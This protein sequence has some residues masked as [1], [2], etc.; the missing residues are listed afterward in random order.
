M[1]RSFVAG[2]E[3]AKDA[4]AQTGE[5]IKNSLED[6]GGGEALDELGEKASEAMEKLG[7]LSK[8]MLEKFAGLG[9]GLK[10]VAELMGVGFL[11]EAITKTVGEFVEL[12]TEVQ[13]T[14]TIMGTSN[15]EAHAWVDAAELSGV[16]ANTF[17]QAARAMNAQ[18]L[19]GGKQLHDMKISLTDAGGAMKT[20]GQL[21]EDGINKLDTYTASANK[22]ALAQKLGGRAWID[23]AANGQ[24][25][26]DNLEKQ[27]EEF[28]NVGSR[29]DILVA[30]TKAM[31]AATAQMSI[32]WQ[33][34]VTSAAPALT[35]ALKSVDE[36]LMALTA[37]AQAATIAIQGVFRMASG[38]ADVA[39][40]I[41]KLFASAGSENPLTDPS[42]AASRAAGMDQITAAAKR[43]GDAF[44]DTGN[45]IDKVYKDL[46]KQRGQLWV[47]HLKMIQSDLQDVGTAGEGVANAAKAPA[48]PANIPKGGGGQKGGGGGADPMAGMDDTLVSS[49]NAMDKMGAEF[50]KF[51]SEA[52]MA[53][54]ASQ[55]SFETLKERATNDYQVMTDAHKAFANAVKTGDVEAA[56]ASEKDWHDASQKF[57]QDWDAAAAKAK[58]DMQQIKARRIKWPARYRAS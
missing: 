7:E 30:Q 48:P 14:A 5:E 46:D 22:N 52:Q 17:A 29:E 39:G 56:K 23:L 27:K 6:S 28:A 55:E 54:K 18:V 20:T 50:Q 38:L 1:C 16:S 34:I 11:G 4:A 36:A 51:G 8:E 15:A 33:D 21:I 37:N 24:L 12:G 35:G 9:E 10:G 26:I 32:S 57:Q 53:S 40:G 2:M 47:D 42:A 19:A 45:Q 25:L 41:G 3:E 43:T 49:Q 31:Q 58:Q 44:T 13:R